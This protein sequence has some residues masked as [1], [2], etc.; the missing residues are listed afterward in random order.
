VAVVHHG[1]ETGNSGRATGSS[2]ALPEKYILFLSTLQPRKNLE[3]LIDAFRVLKNE[4]PEI[5][6]KLVIAGKPGWKF[7]N[8]LKKIQANKDIAVYLNHISETDKAEVLSGADLL[9]LP[10]L[11]EGFGMQ[12]L[13]AFEAGVPVATSN[14]SSMPEVAGE[15]AVYFN[16][17]NV[18]E[19]KNAVKDVLLDK[20][21]A[22][23]L[24]ARGKERLKHFGWEKCARETLKVLTS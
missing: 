13:E 20:S 4:H 7:E 17:K 9:V 23:S 3:K 1:Y 16:P 14:I 15:A 21:L 8:I 5:L 18:Q 2:L 6:H 12:I 22:D 11:Y 19:I 10:S 24:T